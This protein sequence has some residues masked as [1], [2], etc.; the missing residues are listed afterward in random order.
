MYFFPPIEDSLRKK[1]QLAACCVLGEAIP[2]NDMI[3][4]CLVGLQE[5][6]FQPLGRKSWPHAELRRGVGGLWKRF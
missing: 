1:S 5:F 2:F 3:T 4:L 6:A